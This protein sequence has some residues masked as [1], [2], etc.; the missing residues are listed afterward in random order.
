VK[1]PTLK[2]YRMRICRDWVAGYYRLQALPRRR[3][4]VRLPLLATVDNAAPQVRQ[5]AY[6]PGQR[7]RLEATEVQIEEGGLLANA[8]LQTAKPRPKRLKVI[9]AKSGADRMKAATAKASGGDGL[10]LKGATAQEGAAALLRM[11]VE[12]GVMR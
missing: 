8:Q 10:V 4:K 5:A 9:K 6:G 11:L 3:L 1:A 7:G 12:E 2:Q